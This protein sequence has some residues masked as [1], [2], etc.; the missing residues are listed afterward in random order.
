MV[1]IWTI[2]FSAYAILSVVIK[3]P[4]LTILVSNVGFFLQILVTFGIPFRYTFKYEQN[5]A[6]GVSTPSSRD[7]NDLLQTVL[8]NPELKEKFRK[9]LEGMWCA[10]SFSFFFK[11]FFLLYFHFLF[12]NYLIPFFF[13]E[14]EKGK[15]FISRKC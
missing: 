12:Q 2:F 9:F 1:I 14:I 4:Y 8:S 6:S 15:P 11:K 7:P 3:S 13:F 10:V 5:A